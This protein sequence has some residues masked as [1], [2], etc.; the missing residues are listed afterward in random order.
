MLNNNSEAKCIILGGDFNF[1]L[2]SWLETKSDNPPCKEKSVTM[3]LL[4]FVTFGRL[5][6]KNPIDSHFDKII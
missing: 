5:G 2:D 6:I 4:I 1:Y 3:M